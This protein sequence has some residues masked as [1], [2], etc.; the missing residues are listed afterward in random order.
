M[1]QREYVQAQTALEACL[2]K[3]PNY[4]PALADLAIVRYRAMDY[5]GAWDLARRGLAI[6]TYDPASNYYYGLASVRLG[7][8]VDALDGFE[9]AASSPAFRSA[10][11]IELA[12]IHLRQRRPGQGQPT[13]RSAPGCRT[14]TMSRRSSW[15]P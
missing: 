6:D 4:L 5:E 14:M 9:V 7:R 8:T 2:K 13:T 10:A 11:A 12:K 3:D 1:R 15:S